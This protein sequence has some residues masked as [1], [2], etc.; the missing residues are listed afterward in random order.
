MCSGRL[1]REGD[2]SHIELT[3]V[4]AVY[5]DAGESTALTSLLRSYL[6]YD[7]GI[8]DRL[9]FVIVDDGSPF[10]VKLPNDLDLNI[11]LIRINEDI[12]WNQPGARNLGVVYARSDKLLLTDLD[13]EIPEQTFKYTLTM[14]NPGRTIFKMRRVDPLNPNRRPHPNTFVLS[15]AR[16]L[17]YYGYDEEFTG[18]YGFDDSM[19][20]RWQ[21]NHGTRFR[22]LPPSCHAT[23]RILPREQGHLLER[24][25]A[26]N[27]AI[28]E[29][30]KRLW[31]TYGYEAGHSRRFLGFTWNIVD[32][33]RR[34]NP[35]APLR[36]HPLWTRT[37]WWRWLVGDNGRA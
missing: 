8:L 18:H 5:F 13:H 26:H 23:C 6:A 22:Y 35:P 11:L 2:C 16:F 19:F 29:Q 7:K 1:D 17:R 3:Y 9:Q 4:L 37:W 25:L 31:K 36:K 12:P 30:K 27:R 14:N 20:W 21:R 33:H 32:D 34:N 10:P 15:R 28:A 24:D